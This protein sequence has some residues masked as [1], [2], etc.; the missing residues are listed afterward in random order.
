MGGWKDADS[1]TPW[2]WLSEAEEF[3]A[4]LNFSALLSVSHL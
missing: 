3:I 4:A 2:T 1:G